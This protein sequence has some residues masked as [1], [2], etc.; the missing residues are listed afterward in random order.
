MSRFQ[1][2]LCLDMPVLFDN[3]GRQINYVRL[4]ITDRCNLR[5]TY[6]MP[7]EGIKYG[8]RSTLLSYEEILRLMRILA[9][10]GIDKVRVTG[11]EPLIRRDVM[12]LFTGLAAIPGISSIALTTNGTVTLPKV[13]QLKDLGI[14]KINLSLDSLDPDRFAQITR[15]NDFSIV[16]QT[17][18]A[19]VAEGFEVKTNT[20]MLE[21]RNDKDLI[22]FAELTQQY[23]VD[24]RFIEE[25]PFNG[26]GEN[27][28]EL[29]WN[30]KRIF[31]TLQEHFPDIQKLP[32]PPNSTA[33]H[34]QIPGARG[35]IG[36]I[37]AYTRSFC[38]T[39]NRLRITPTGVLK[40]C[41]YDSGVFNIRD[42]L[43]AGATDDEVV[44]AILE[45]VGNRAKNGF[46][47]EARRL[48]GTPVNESMTTIGG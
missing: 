40:T 2:Y 31:D 10:L 43:R 12:D 47:A 44:T 27:Q 15:R 39:C 32:D 26:S 8:P 17:F 29:Y 1:Q 7:A 33:L 13:P 18:E 35:A 14:M 20:V 37:P 46:E 4:A 24:V 6:C 30:W 25:M 41:L 11:G 5:C 21:G 22:P 42:L 34:Y 16:W 28:S 38:G 36:I 23:P 9:G 19:L 45:A 3:H 48:G